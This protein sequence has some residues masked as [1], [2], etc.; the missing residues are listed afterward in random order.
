[1]VETNPESNLLSVSTYNYDGIVVS[2]PGSK[3]AA[4]LKEWLPI[5]MDY[6]LYFSYFQLLIL[7]FASL[8]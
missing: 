8:Y 6:T 1:M 5:R 2:E 4:Y 7:V 3:Q